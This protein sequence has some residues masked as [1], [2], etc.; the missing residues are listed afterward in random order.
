[1][2]IMVV[3]LAVPIS[4]MLG[5]ERHFDRRQPRAQ[6]ARKTTPK[7]RRLKFLG[8]RSDSAGI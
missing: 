5:V 3:L 1:M 7:A 2:V 4:T 8:C 6:A